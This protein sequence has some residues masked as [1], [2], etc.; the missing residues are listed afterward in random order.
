MGALIHDGPE[1]YLVD[2]PTP[3][4]R[5]DGVSAGYKG[6][7]TKM[8]VAMY[9]SFGFRLL[10]KLEHELIKWAD[11]LALRIEAANLLPSRGRG[12]GVDMPHMNHADMHLFPKVE[13][14][15]VVAERFTERF[16]QL[17]ED[18]LRDAQLHRIA[19]ASIKTVTATP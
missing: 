4:K 2:L 13:R 6:L 3:V 15:N 9:T 18:A 16:E 1:A 12:W 17:R 7:E 14:W 5:C 11:M 19:K 10:T 8:E